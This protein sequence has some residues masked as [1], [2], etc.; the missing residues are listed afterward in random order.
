MD[1]LG[2]LKALAPTVATCLGG[3]LAG[4]A[5]S[6]LGSILGVPEPT[7][8]KISQMFQDGQ[9]TPDHL[10]QIRTLEIQYQNDEKE[11]GFRYADL[12]FKDTADAR[13]MLMNTHSYTP[14]IL[15]WIVVA[16]FIGIEGALLLGVAPKVDDI[17]LGRILATL[18]MSLALVLGFWFGSSNNQPRQPPK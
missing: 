8:D 7:Q 5:V 14:A 16:A 18:D 1:W 13:Q 4:A 11:R 9:L 10:A 3:P 15:T 17:V 6:A 12:Q 2:T